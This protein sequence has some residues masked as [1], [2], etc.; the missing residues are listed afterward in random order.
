MRVCVCMFAC[1][2]MCLCLCV[3]VF[4]CV[5]VCMLVCV[6]VCVCVCVCVRVCEAIVLCNLLAVIPG[7]LAKA[8]PITR[9]GTVE[10][11]PYH[12]PCSSHPDV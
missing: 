11:A 8:M 1:M 3:C 10:V 5:F 6:Y 12:V 7:P 9:H 2:C 4:V